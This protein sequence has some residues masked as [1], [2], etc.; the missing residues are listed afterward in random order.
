MTQIASSLGSWQAPRSV[1]NRQPLQNEP[2]YTQQLGP[3]LPL[4]SVPAELGWHQDVPRAQTSHMLT[5][6]FVPQDNCIGKVSDDRGNVFTQ[7]FSLRCQPSRQS[8]LGVDETICSVSGS[9]KAAAPFCLHP[10]SSQMG[11]GRAEAR[12][13]CQRRAA[14]REGKGGWSPFPRH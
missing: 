9:R 7:L 6:L 14:S 11:C 13:F 3:V 10:G 1:C 2:R 5:P 4:H 8:C 12:Q